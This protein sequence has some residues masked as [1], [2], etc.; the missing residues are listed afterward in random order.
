M[1]LYITLTNEQ[2]PSELHYM[3]YNVDQAMREEAF[4]ETKWM[5]RKDRV[6]AL[7]NEVNADI[8]TL[9]EMRKL[10]NTITVNEWLAT[11]F[12]QYY[13][14]I[15]FRNASALSFG[16]ANLYNPNKFYADRTV[17]RWL[18]DTPNV[19]SDT[20][21]SSAGGSTGFG[22]LVLATRFLWVFE[23]KVVENKKP[24]WVFNV[25]FG[26]EEDLKTKS[27]AK[28]LEIVKEVSGGESSIISGDF[29]LFPDRDA[30]KQRAILVS[31]F[32]DIGEGAITSQKAQKVEGTFV[33]FEHDSFKADLKNMVSRLDHIFT[34]PKTNQFVKRDP[35]QLITKTMLVPEPEE[36][37]VRHLPSDH[38]PISVK[39]TVV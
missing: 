2:L 27:C 22:Y 8:I 32:N 14:E 28:L 37:S 12:P 4:P 17:K 7:I 20:W 19:I 35:A 6:A 21:A 31:E 24:F 30:T 26:L 10:P 18:S 13:Y 16:Q 34:Y 25:H 9:Q 5:A 11:S 1:S 23:G 15:G 29:N 3:T 39:L 38:L 36:L 33:G